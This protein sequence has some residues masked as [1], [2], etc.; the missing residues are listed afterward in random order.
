MIK[1][2]ITLERP[3]CRVFG[4]LPMTET[5]RIYVADETYCNLTFQLP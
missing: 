1:G 2:R 3:K 4:S 5:S